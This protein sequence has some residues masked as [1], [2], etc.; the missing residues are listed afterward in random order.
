LGCWKFLVNC[1][2][3]LKI[4]YKVTSILSPSKV[5]SQSKVFY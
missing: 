2:T 5:A 4:Q 1:K 3:N